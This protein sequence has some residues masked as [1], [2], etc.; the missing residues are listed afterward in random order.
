MMHAKNKLY[1]DHE[2]DLTQMEIRS[3]VYFLYNK[4]VLVYVGKATNI[5][6]GILDHLE[7][8]IKEFDQVRYMVVPVDSLS[9]VETTLIKSLKPLYNNTQEPQKGLTYPT[10][11]ITL[12]PVILP[13][14]KRRNGS[15]PVY[16]RM[17][18]KRRNKYF[19]TNLIAYE[20][21]IEDGRIINK[22]IL[23]DAKKIIKPFANATKFI[24]PEMSF[25]FV[26]NKLSKLY[27]GNNI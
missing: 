12:N 22:Q 3:G 20:E 4:G 7:E 14:G 25:E 6:R 1:G 19:R 13:D 15:Y 27:Y 9:N 10:S 16:I 24:S 18:Y 21:D 11:A 23:K 17:T 5:S 8:G 26:K 2:I